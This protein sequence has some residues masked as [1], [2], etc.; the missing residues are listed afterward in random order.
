VFW[1]LLI[2]FFCLVLLTQWITKHV[3]GIGYLVTGDGQVALY[4]YYLLI[5]PGI[6]IHELSHALAALLM[7]VKVRR[8]SLGIQRKRSGGQVSLGSVEIAATGP[9]RA[10]LIGLAPFV[11]GCAA[12]LLIGGRVFGFRLPIPFSLARFWQE[13]QTASR[14]PDFGLWV[15]FVFAIG[16]AMLPSAA[17]R[18]AWGTTLLFMLIVG[19][20]AYLTGVLDSAPSVRRATTAVGDWLWTAGEQLTYA[21]AI[22]VIVDVVVAATLFLIEQ[23]LALFGL[24]RLEYR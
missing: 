10:S 2:L 8:M 17:D 18:G 6:L 5:F 19:L 24:G 15:Y 23:A 12:I 9:L 22:A 11:A 4:L 1:S 13:I 7:G 14:V 3:Q 16:N 20:V 21:F